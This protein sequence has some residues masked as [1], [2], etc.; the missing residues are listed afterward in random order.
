MN[1]KKKLRLLFG[2]CP[3]C[4]EK[5]IEGMGGSSLLFLSGL[6]VCPKKHYAEELHMTGATLVYDNGGKPL[7]I[8]GIGDDVSEDLRTNENK[9]IAGQLTGKVVEYAQINNRA[10]EIRFTDDTFLDIEL[11]ENACEIITS[12]DDK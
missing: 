8:D 1:I 9:I 2:R 4:K 5:L 3:Y 6:K 11:D 10:I 7:N 12:L